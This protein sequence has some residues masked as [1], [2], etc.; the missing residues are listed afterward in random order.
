MWSI[1]P[2]SDPAALVD[3][4]RPIS[5]A[6]L[7]LAAYAAAELLTTAPAPSMPK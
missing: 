3:A 5:R 1:A 2:R 4:A 6:P 7:E